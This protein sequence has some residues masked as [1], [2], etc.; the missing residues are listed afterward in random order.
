MA[1]P[2]LSLRSVP[3]ASDG[4]AP[5]AVYF[6][7]LARR[8]RSRRAP[9]GRLDDRPPPDALLLQQRNGE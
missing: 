5:E 4:A 7:N 2:S 3:A 9:G 8:A 6:R 1:R